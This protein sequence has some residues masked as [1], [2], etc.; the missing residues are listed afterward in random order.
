M[1]SDVNIVFDGMS[2]TPENPTYEEPVI[3]SKSS[4]SVQF[5][6]VI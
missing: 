4:P 5:A 6:L 1:T 2:R 3:A